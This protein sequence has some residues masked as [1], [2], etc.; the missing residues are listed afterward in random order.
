MKDTDKKKEFIELRAKNWSYQR[1]SEKIGVS[2]N[3]LIKWNRN[4]NY[5][6]NNIKNLEKE[7]LYTQYKMNVEQ[8]IKYLGELQNKILLELQN[9]DL[10]DVNAD[11]LLDMLFKTTE[12]LNESKTDTFIRT[13][14]EIKERKYR[15]KHPVKSDFDKVIDSLSN[16]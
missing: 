1:I 15:D 8:K 5:E 4:F 6:I 16:L 3:T 12:K 2:K 14:Q 13:E 11:K 10:S 7:S 9:R